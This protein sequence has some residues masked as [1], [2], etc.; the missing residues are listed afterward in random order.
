L[1]Q[2]S[3]RLLTLWELAC[4]Q[5]FVLFR[6]DEHYTDHCGSEPAREGVRSDNVDVEC[7]G[8]FASRLAPT[9]DLGSAEDLLINSSPCGGG[10]FEI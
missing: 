2:S 6:D 8:L 3:E 9:L 1:P 5:G 7:K 4:Q 10:V